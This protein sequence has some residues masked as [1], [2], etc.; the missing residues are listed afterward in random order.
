MARRRRMSETSAGR[1]LGVVLAVGLV[2]GP[3]GCDPKGRSGERQGKQ[4][5]EPKTQQPVVS[6]ALPCAGQTETADRQAP[7]EPT[8][9]V[10]V[11]PS[12]PELPTRAKAAPTEEP[13]GPVKIDRITPEVLKA[14]QQAW[15]SDEPAPAP[16][17][18][19]N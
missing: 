3:M 1:L 6:P 18:G 5:P 7:V 8:P 9:A 13:D 2:A 19:K 12:K 10:V 11:K 16:P 14:L 17:A 15:G 4:T